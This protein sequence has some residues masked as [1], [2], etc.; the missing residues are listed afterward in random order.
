MS[1]HKIATG[2]WFFILLDGKMNI[3]GVAV[4]IIFVLVFIELYGLNFLFVLHYLKF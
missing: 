4:S 1:L 3:D 2:K